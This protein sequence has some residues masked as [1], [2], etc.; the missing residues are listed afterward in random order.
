MAS[1]QSLFLQQKQVDRMMEEYRYIFASPTDVL[2]HFQV[3]HP[4]DLTPS[5]TLPNELFYHHSLME[6]DEIKNWIQELLQKR[7]IKPRSSPCGSSIVLV[8]NKDGT[9]RIFI[10]YR[11][12][13]KI[14]VRNQYPIPRIDDLLDQ[15]KEAKF[16]NKI[17]L[18][19]R[20]HQ[21]PIKL[22]DV[23]KTTFKS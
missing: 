4:I 6:N 13:N 19:S 12:V 2:M 17:D 10:D 14:I 16:F 20:Y 1:T 11:E 8:K 5:A 23:W 7:H 21:V 9:W 18:K 15:L 22:T 3:K